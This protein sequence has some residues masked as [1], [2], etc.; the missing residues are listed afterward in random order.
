MKI[1]RIAKS[2]LEG[3]K[4]TYLKDFHDLISRIL[5]KLHMLKQYDIWVRINTKINRIK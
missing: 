3:G 4:K 5:K 2:I 1:T